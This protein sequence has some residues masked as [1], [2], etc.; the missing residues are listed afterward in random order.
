MIEELQFPVGCR[1]LERWK[2]GDVVAEKRLREIFD[3]TIAGEYDEVFSEAAPANKVHCSASLN[4]MT[5][6]IMY[7]L[8]GLDS[9]AFYKGDPERYVRTTLMSRKLLGMNKM[10]VSWVVII[11]SMITGLFQ[12]R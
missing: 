7:E 2:T 8:Y 3:A 11:L 6:T 9:A 5:L 4:L 1:L 12:R 10:Y